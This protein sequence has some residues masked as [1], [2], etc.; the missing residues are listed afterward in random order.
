MNAVICLRVLASACEV[1]ITFSCIMYLRCVSFCVFCFLLKSLCAFKA[2]AVAC[3]YFA[4][5]VCYWFGR[6]CAVLY[7]FSPALNLMFRHCICNDLLFRFYSAFLLHFLFC[8]V[9]NIV[10]LFLLLMFAVFCARV[11]PAGLVRFFLF[12]VLVL[13]RLT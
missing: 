13:F 12:C 3:F 11:A 4:A 2:C 8:F 7:A 9:R 10:S 1:K 5:F 6:C